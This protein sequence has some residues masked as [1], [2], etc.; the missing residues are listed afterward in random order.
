M[1]TVL[2]IIFSV[3]VITSFISAGIFGNMTEITEALISGADEAVRLSFSMLGV[4]C[5]WSGIIRVFEKAGITDIIT[6][7]ISPLIRLIYP[8][9]YKNNNA[10]NEIAA[11]YSA[12][13]LGLGNA[14]LPL[15]INAMKKMRNDGLP[16]KDTANDEMIMFA[17]INTAPFQLIPTTIIALKNAHNSSNPSE[18]IL[19]IWI[20]SLLTTVFAV[21]L[22]KTLSRITRK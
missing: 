20:C 4:M 17:V 21:I 5:L 18:I 7:I 15:G 1:N 16:E 22:C 3:L 13:L 19:P 11:D 6:R 8:K 14:A 9:T 10:V 2:G 12:N